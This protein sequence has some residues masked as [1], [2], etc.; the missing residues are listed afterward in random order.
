[1]K[2]PAA[3]TRP[4]AGPG[5]KSTVLRVLPGTPIVPQLS[6]SMSPLYESDDEF[7][8]NSSASQGK[9]MEIIMHDTKKSSLHP[10]TI[11]TLPDKDQQRIACKALL[12]QRCTNKGI[13][14]WDR[15][16]QTHTL[17]ALFMVRVI[18]LTTTSLYS[19]KSSSNSRI[20]EVNSAPRWW[21]SWASYSCKQDINPL[22][23]KL[24]KSLRLCI[25]T[26]SKTPEDS[27]KPST[28][29]R[30]TS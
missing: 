26:T 22:E 15:K 11:L 1:M 20:L 21:N 10:H 14:F 25:I 2:P 23:I 4:K 24:M 17:I 27:S 3:A 8:Q 30:I 5:D 7:T 28:S 16:I 19:I 29:S 13:I 6:T 18:L 9:N 12:D